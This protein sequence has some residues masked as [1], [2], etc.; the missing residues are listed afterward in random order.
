MNKY[1]PHLFEPLTVNG[2]TFKNRIFSA[3]NMMCYMDAAGFPTPDMIAYYAEKAKGGAAVVTIGDTPVDK[4]HAA[5]NPRSFTLAYPNLPFLAEMAMAIHEH[6]AKASLELNHAGCVAVPEANDGGYPIGPVDMIRD[7][8][9]VHVHAMT[10]EDMNEVADRFAD[11]AELLKTAGFDMCLVHG[12]HGWLL[13]QFLSPLTN[14]RTDEYGGSIENRARFPLMVIDRIRQRVGPRFLIEY[15]MSG[16]ECIEGGYGIEDALEFA[17]LIDG[18]V[19]LIHVSAALDV[20]EA[21]AVITH[22]TMFLPHGVNVKYA[23]EIKKHVKTPVVTI[24]AISDPEMAED[25]L[26]T[27]KADV[28]AMVRALIADPHLPNKARKGKAEEIAPCMRCLDCLTGMHTGQHFQCAV[29][30]SAGREQRYRNYIQPAAESKK[31]L[32]VGG[33]PGGM[34]AAITAAQR[35]H[36]VT[37]AEKTDS[38]GGLLKFTD[39]DTLK[40]DLGRVKK[41]LVHMTEKSGAEILLNTEVTPE[42]VREGG[43][44]SV[45]VAAGS[46]PLVLP[47]PGLNDPSVLHALDIYTNMDKIGKDVALLG[48]GLVGC[49]TA[50]FLAERGHNV[51]IIEMQPEIAPEANWMHKEGMMQ[52]FAKQPITC[53]TGWKV[54][55]V[56]KNGVYAVDKDGV[57]HFTPA[58]SVVFAMG[59]RANSAT[60][61]ALADTA[62]DVVAVGDCVRARKSCHAMLEGFWAAVDLA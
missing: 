23:A 2:V 58:D 53:R 4:E 21:Q 42:F 54:A 3:P 15:R 16:D 22:P 7:Y 39:Y 25:I 11:G 32:V 1:Y 35:G 9:G 60:V 47:I 19:D 56:E 48:G 5:S 13:H 36:D 34:K 46:S 24:G 30:P 55:R 10:E 62:E 50:L 49:E 8:D 52:A 33:G 20:E 31:V 45:I 29:N 38:L 14:T 43:Y 12:G 18:K 26:A 40:A 59:M 27:G 6:G 51:T 41:W 17:K 28:V 37:L 61:D 44:D 57:E